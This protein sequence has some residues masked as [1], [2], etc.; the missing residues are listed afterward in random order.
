MLS[1]LTFLIAPASRGQS[2]PTENIQENS[3]Q[4]LTSEKLLLLSDLRSLDEQSVKLD[5][6]LSRALVKVEIADAAWTLDREWAEELLTKAY[7]LTY[8]DEDERVKLRNKAAG[9]QPLPPSSVN[10]ARMIVRSRVMKVAAREKAFADQLIRLSTEQLGNYENHLLY[11]TLADNARQEKDMDAAGQ[12]FLQAVDDDPSQIAA[13][14]ILID[15][16]KS[17][18]AKADKLIIE[19]LDRLR[20]FPLSSANGSLFRVYFVIHRLVFPLVGTVSPSPAVMRAYVIYVVQ[21]LGNLEEREPGSLKGYRWFL[22]KAWLPLKQYAPELS[23]A[24][25]QLERLSRD[26]LPDAKQKGFEEEI[27]DRYDDNVRNALESHHPDEATINSAMNRGDFNKAR[28]MIDK[29]DEGVLKT[30]LTETVNTREALSL[31]AAGDTLGAEVLAKRLNQ[32]TSI[33]QVYPAI[34]KK[35]VEKKDQPSAT[36]LV[37]QAI[38]QLERASTEPPTLPGGQ[39]LPP[40]IMKSDPML[41][42]LSNLAKAITPINELLGLEV[43]DKMIIA[44]NA[45]TLSAGQGRIGFDLDVL[46]KLAPKDEARVRL[47]AQSL[48]DPVS[49]MAAL[50]AIYQ[51]KAA[52]LDKR[53]TRSPTTRKTIPGSN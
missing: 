48:K 27:K 34:I 14:F 19:Y 13:G 28:K 22:L 37:Y 8:P 18:R 36:N 41:L 5:A 33:L 32:A 44:S 38:K 1:L 29:L 53:A 42:S 9:S 25:L 12:Y 49:Q 39:P 40:Q 30:R 4:L 35:C 17:D 16:A 24:F 31:A 26:P 50:A 3:D 45:S 11:A 15:I 46:R 6:P 23:G 43:L 52:D 2:S 51:W 20:A 21:S 10:S 47:A 7:E